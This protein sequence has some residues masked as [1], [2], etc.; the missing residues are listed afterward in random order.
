MRAAILNPE[1]LPF[2][3]LK[4]NTN[5]KT[6]AGLSFAALSFDV[7]LF[8]ASCFLFLIPHFL[9]LAS[10]FLFLFTPNQP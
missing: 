7:Y 3:L 6:S 2:T 9:L 8:L 1:F 5:P 10:C 4:L